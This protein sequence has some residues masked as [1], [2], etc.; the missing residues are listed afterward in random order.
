MS[1][2]SEAVL[3]PMV[4]GVGKL[5]RTR[6][7][8]VQALREEIAA[9]GNFSAA[10][11]AARA[12][13]SAA[14]FYNHF[15][16][17]DDALI[18]AYES[19]MQDLV[20]LVGDQCR[21]ERL[22]DLGLRDFL[23]EW[24]ERAVTFFRDNSALFRLAQAATTTSRGMRDVFRRYE[25]QALEHY[26]RFIQLGQAANRIREGDR[27]SMARVLLVMSESWN[28]PMMRSA[29]PGSAFHHEW[30]E[31]LARTLAREASDG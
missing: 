18:A 20:A 2:A 5:E 28:H 27:A 10:G 30:T 3:M 1:E 15:A 25:A 22:L 31:S 12:G 4:P 23:A 17:Q 16:S 26:E 6:R 29:E 7:R 9:T 21:I 19:L 8:L 14:T 11:V 13:T 24:L